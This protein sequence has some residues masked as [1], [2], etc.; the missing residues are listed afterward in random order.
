MSLKLCGFEKMSIWE[1]GFYSVDIIAP[2]LEWFLEP[3]EV[4]W[5]NKNRQMILFIF[6]LILKDAD[7][8]FHV[9]YDPVKF[10]LYYQSILYKIV[11]QI[12][13]SCVDFDVFFSRHYHVP[14]PTPLFEFK[15]DIIEYFPHSGMVVTGYYLVILRMLEGV[16]AFCHDFFYCLTKIFRCIYVAISMLLVS[17]WQ[18]KKL[19][20]QSRDFKDF[21]NDFASQRDF[22]DSSFNGWWSF[23]LSMSQCSKLIVCMRTSNLLF[24]LRMVIFQVKNHLGLLMTLRLI[25][26]VPLHSYAL[27]YLISKFLLKCYVYLVRMGLGCINED[28]FQHLWAVTHWVLAMCE[29]SFCYQLNFLFPLFL[30]FSGVFPFRF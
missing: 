14:N 11:S 2:S 15:G 28:M 22:V 7:F 5:H 18:L 30:L 12:I 19:H 4:E 1:W 6:F 23:S 21:P 25:I 17:H 26:G 3:S 20:I 27:D 24:I 29:L 9:F 10:S 16:L 13:K 8:S